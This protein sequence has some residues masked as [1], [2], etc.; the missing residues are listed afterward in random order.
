MRWHIFAAMILVVVVAALG[1]WL[2]WPGHGS[3]V[4]LY[5]S[6]DQDHSRGEVSLFEQE[7][8][9]TV[10]FQGDLEANKSVGLARRLSAEREKPHADVFWANEPMNTAWLADA[11]AFDPLPDDVLAKFPAAWRDPD[12]RFVM[13]GLRARVLLV[14]TKLLP[15]AADRPTKVADLVDPKYGA[16]GL[17]TAMAVPL[18]GTTYSHAVALL[19]RDAEGTKAWLGRV[20]AAS[21]EKRL[22]LTPGNGPAMRLVSDASNKVAFCL[23]DTDDAWAAK[24]AGAPVE[25]VYPDQGAGGLGTV[26]MPNTLSIVKGRPHPDAALRLLAWLA[27]PKLEARLASG[28]SAQM[29]VRPDVPVPADG[30]VKRPGTDFTV[31]AVDW[32]EVA[33]NRDRWQDTLENMF[34]PGK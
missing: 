20:V 33:K 21:T 19:T 14:N 10:E 6:V 11:G 17:K 1:V 26:V 31:M 30:H 29:P 13:L 22:I 34:L 8:G 23:T 27:D 9:L 15:D 12:K 7:T 18:T 24:L 5:C 25:I 4:V 2:Y 16:L 32:R 3:D 28:P